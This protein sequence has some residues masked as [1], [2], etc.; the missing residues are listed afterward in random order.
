MWLS[1][2]CTAEC[3]RGSNLNRRTRFGRFLNVFRVLSSII[4]GAAIASVGDLRSSSSDGRIRLFPSSQA[5]GCC[6]SKAC[7]VLLIVLPGWWVFALAT[8]AM[9]FRWRHSAGVTPSIFFV[10]FSNIEATVPLSG[11]LWLGCVAIAGRRCWRL[12]FW[13]E[14]YG[15]ASAICSPG[16][17]ELRSVVAG[18]LRFLASK[19][20]DFHSSRRF[21]LVVAVVLDWR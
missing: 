1:W 19:V 4:Y 17:T 15:P 13:F 5:T 21:G 8:I 7:S 6:S 20:D 10:G 14:L 9:D 3:T 16:L 11:A 18:T 2:R 12:L